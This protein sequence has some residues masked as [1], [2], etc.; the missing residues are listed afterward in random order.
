M[1]PFGPAPDDAR[2]AATP[3]RPTPT[4]WNRISVWEVIGYT[5]V[6]LFI[7]AMALGWFDLMLPW[8]TK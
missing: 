3:K 8:D 5:C 1:T 4:N 6:I 7:A 2:P